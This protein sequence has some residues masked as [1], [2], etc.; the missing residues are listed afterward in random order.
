MKGTVQEHGKNTWRLKWELPRSADGRR[1]Q[2]SKVVHGSKAEAQSQLR[3]VLSSLDKGEYV[4]RS[5]ITVSDFL[6]LWLE[7]Y[8]SANTSPGTQQSYNGIVNWYIRPGLGAILLTS[9][10]PEHV[11]TVSREN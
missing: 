1:H 5:K 7:S 10:R 8:V 11:Q 2:G 9:L 3:S 6:D 4:T